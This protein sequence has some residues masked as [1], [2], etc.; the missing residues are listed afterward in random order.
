MVGEITR[1]N[2]GLEEKE[3]VGYN[4]VTWEIFMAKYSL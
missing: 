2:L 3:K 4:K 1:N